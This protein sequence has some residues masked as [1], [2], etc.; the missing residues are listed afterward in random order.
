MIINIRG[1]NGSGKS[2]VVRKLMEQ[3][4]C[5]VPIYGILGTRRP[6]AYR[7]TVDRCPRSVVVL[8]PY[9]A[10]TGGC[11][12]LGSY[13]RILALFDKYRTTSHVVCEGVWLSDTWGKLGK[14]FERHA[15]EV[16]LVFLDTPLEECLR[17]LGAR[18]AA[19]GTTCT[20]SSTK[21]QRRYQYVLNV[22]QRVEAAGH[23]RTETASSGDAARHIQE[24]MRGA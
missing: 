10:D 9:L 17:R 8:G 14:Y 7:L 3:A 15:S 21:T 12:C 2:T 18:R 6:E 19:A 20:L 16:V 23:I 24:I 11:D 5:C 1:T 4:V 22:R 13:A